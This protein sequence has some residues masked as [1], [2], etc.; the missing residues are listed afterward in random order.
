MWISDSLLLVAM[1]MLL[2]ILVLSPYV[3]IVNVLL[4][5]TANSKKKTLYN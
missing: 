5:S 1:I 4:T 2:P 3:G